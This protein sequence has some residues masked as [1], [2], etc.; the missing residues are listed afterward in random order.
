MPPE[1]VVY[2]KK[3]VSAIIKNKPGLIKRFFATPELI[4]KYGSLCKELAKQHTIYRQVTQEEL[5]KICDT[6]HHEGMAVVIEKPSVPKADQNVIEEWIK[7]KPPILIL[8]NITNPHNLGAICRTA[9]FLGFSQ[10]VT[11]EQGIHS[12]SAWRVSEGAMLWSQVYKADNLHSVIMSLKPNFA[13]CAADIRGNTNLKVFQSVPGKGVAL[14]LGNEESGI[15]TGLL[16]T[17]DF[18]VF[19]DGNPQ[20]DSL[21]VSVA[22][23]IF[24]WKL[25]NTLQRKS[26]LDT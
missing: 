26:R 10:I 21:N 8:D 20:I 17:A 7:N 1:L 5:E 12:G 14:I 23:G 4:K 11:A 24:L 13:I 9:V 16:N 19:I 22:A 3:A 15:S 6:I 25:A 18:R 2:G